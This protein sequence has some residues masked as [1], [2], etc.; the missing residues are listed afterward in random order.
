[1]TEQRGRETANEAE[2]ARLWPTAAEPTRWNARGRKSG[3]IGIGIELG[4]A[5]GLSG[6]GS[7]S[8]VRSRSKANDRSTPLLSF[9]RAVQPPPAGIIYVYYP[10]LCV[11]LFPIYRHLCPPSSSLVRDVDFLVCCNIRH[12]KFAVEIDGN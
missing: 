9:L 8:P 4:F 11:S 6:L 7:D 10:P 1:M 3:G 12:A 5:L 2:S